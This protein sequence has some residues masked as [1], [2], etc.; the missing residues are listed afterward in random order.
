M[1]VL[2][3]SCTKKETVTTTPNIGTDWIAPSAI[4]AMTPDSVFYL[5]DYEGNQIGHTALE[6]MPLMPYNDVFACRVNN[7]VY[8]YNIADP[9]KRL[10]TEPFEDISDFRTGYAYATRTG[11]PIMVVNRLGKVVRVL[12]ERIS[13]VSTA[14]FMTSQ[15]ASAR[16]ETDDQCMGI[17]RPNGEILIEFN[18]DE[19]CGFLNDNRITVFDSKTKK[20]RVVDMKGKE[21]FTLNDGYYFTNTNYSDGWIGV[22]N[23][24]FTESFFV[25]IDGNHVYEVD[26]ESLGILRFG[27]I[28]VTTPTSRPGD[29]YNLINVNDGTTVISDVS[30]FYPVLNSNMKLFAALTTDD[31]GE[32]KYAII[33]DQGYLQNN[34]TIENKFFTIPFGDIAAITDGEVYALYDY[35]TGKQVS[36]TPYTDIAVNLHSGQIFNEASAFKNGAKDLAQYITNSGLQFNNFLYSASTTPE[37]V[38]ASAGIDMEDN[39]LARRLEYLYNLGHNS[40]NLNI[41]D[42][43]MIFTFDSNPYIERIDTIE[44]LNLYTIPRYN[45]VLNPDCR[46]QTAT[47][48]MSISED[49]STQ[50]ATKTLDYLVENKGFTR[51]AD[52][53]GTVTNGT[54]NVILV[55]TKGR[56]YITVAFTDIDYD[57]L[58]SG[59][60]SRMAVYDPGISLYDNSD[61]E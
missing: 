27:D 38:I 21:I 60:N 5:L 26:H 30:L 12:P 24:D 56:L 41:E 23:E 36:E 61:S 31:G 37:Q 4:T 9:T 6:G 45:T 22:A 34:I 13:A 35:R 58:R 59:L 17:M 47:L 20:S 8:V 10:N 15:F 40:L 28:I 2:C 51:L 11:R 33:D 53:S 48:T 16:F 39:D 44:Y 14:E 29:T 7:E 55:P 42:T 1:T 32:N 50:L 52:G 18:R 25:D 49:L 46:L 19:E 3:A 57:K 54:I 43:P